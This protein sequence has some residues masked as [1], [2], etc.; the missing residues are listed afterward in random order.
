MQKLVL[1]RGEERIYS[2]IES[3]VWEKRNS[4]GPKGQ[5]VTLCKEF[6]HHWNKQGSVRRDSEE[7]G[8][9]EEATGL[10][11]WEGIQTSSCGLWGISGAFSCRSLSS[12]DIGYWESQLSLRSQVSVAS[13]CLE[14]WVRGVPGQGDDWHSSSTPQ[15]HRLKTILR[16]SWFPRDTELIQIL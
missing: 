10:L 12:G 16:I 8:V 5:D 3:S 13:S 1:K 6:P 14:G 15:L 2:I 4:K 7:R 9:G 11:P